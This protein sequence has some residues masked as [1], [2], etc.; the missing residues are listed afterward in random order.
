[1][2][3]YGRCPL[4]GDSVGSQDKPIIVKW[5]PADRPDVLV[6]VVRAAH[7]HKKVLALTHVVGSPGSVNEGVRGFVD[8]R[9]PMRSTGFGRGV[10]LPARCATAIM[11][12]IEPSASAVADPR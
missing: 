10:L 2:P 4:A 1:M 11:V 7:V 5:S 6:T 12:P 9:P 8:S 3:H